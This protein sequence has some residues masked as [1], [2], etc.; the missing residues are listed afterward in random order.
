MVL[1]SSAP[2]VRVLLPRMICSPVPLAPEPSVIDATVVAPPV[3]ISN[4]ELFEIS[5]CD[6]EGT[7]PVPLAKNCVLAEFGPNCSQVLAAAG[8]DIAD[9]VIGHAEL[10]SRKLV[11]VG[12]G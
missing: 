6:V 11:P 4:A 1:L 5:T 7:P 2:T 12:A 9:R 10:A 3:E 8:V